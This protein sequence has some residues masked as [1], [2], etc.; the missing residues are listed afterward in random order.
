MHSRDKCPYISESL[1]L[2]SCLIVFQGA[3]SHTHQLGQTAELLTGKSKAIPGRGLETSL[4]KS[5]S[6]TGPGSDDICHNG[7]SSPTF[8]QNWCFP[9]SLIECNLCDVSNSR[10]PTTATQHC[11]MLSRLLERWELPTSARPNC[12]MTPLS[13]AGSRKGFVRF[14]PL[15]PT[16]SYS[17]WVP[18]TSA[19]IR[20]RLCK[21]I[22]DVLSQL[23]PRLQKGPAILASI[24][25]LKSFF[26][27]L[28]S[29]CS[30]AKRHSWTETDSEQSSLISSNH[31]LQEMSHQVKPGAQAQFGRVHSMS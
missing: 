24:W 11:H 29:R 5:F 9:A 22:C 15:H 1:C 13:A 14:W 16:I 30:A 31:F 10:P 23:R 25:M 4:P 21:Q 3:P 28:A 6:C 19:A 26:Q 17:A 8:L 2:I 12:R 27:I 7:R 18:R 20:T